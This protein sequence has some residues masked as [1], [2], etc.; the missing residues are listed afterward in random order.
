M[1]QVTYPGSA[2]AGGSGVSGGP[3]CHLSLSMG[4]RLRDTDGRDRCTLGG[5]CRACTM[6]CDAIAA[7]TT[8]YG[9]MLEIPCIYLTRKANQNALMR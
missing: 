1:P 9:K 8:M 2:R 3:A 7:T 6:H 4:Y 5:D